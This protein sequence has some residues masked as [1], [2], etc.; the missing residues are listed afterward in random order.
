MRQSGDYD[1]WIV[2]DANEILPLMDSV[3]NY[4]NTLLS[5]IEGKA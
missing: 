3:D 4:L 2:I 1:D 5:L